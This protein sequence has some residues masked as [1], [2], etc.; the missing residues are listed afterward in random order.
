MTI[1]SINAV[2][3]AG[4]VLLVGKLHHHRIQVETELKHKHTH[5]QS[6]THSDTHSHLVNEGSPFSNPV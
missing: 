3:V 4:A 6:D 2:T 5:T 1:S